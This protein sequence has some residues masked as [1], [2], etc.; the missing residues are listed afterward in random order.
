VLRRVVRLAEGGC[1]PRGV[2]R[3]IR[4]PTPDMPCA[5][6]PMTA[7][8]CTR[9]PSP[10]RG[11]PAYSTSTLEPGQTG[12]LCNHRVDFSTSRDYPAMSDRLRLKWICTP[13]CLWVL[14]EP[15]R[16]GEPMRVHYSRSGNL[17]AESTPSPADLTR[18]LF[19]HRPVLTRPGPSPPSIPS[20]R[21][22]V[23]VR[24]RCLGLR[25]RDAD[26]TNVILA[27]CGIS[28]ITINSWVSMPGGRRRRSRREVTVDN[29]SQDFILTYS[30]D[31]LIGNHSGG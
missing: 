24:R 13:S 19:L 7:K 29:C 4:A 16:H 12:R 28:D 25:L 8:R 31:P 10:P 5:D 18:K 14:V 15:S 23:F 22:W 9:P 26:G 1:P 2:G 20:A 6:A 30:P 11:Q 21:P 3:T 17:S 27:C